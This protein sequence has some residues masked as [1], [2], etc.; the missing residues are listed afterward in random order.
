MFLRTLSLCAFVLAMASCQCS[1][2]KTLTASVQIATAKGPVRFDVELARTDKEREHGLMERESM[3]PN[4]GMLFLFESDDDHSFWMKN[5][6]LPLDLIFFNQDF[7]VVGVIE[8][9]EPM[10]RVSRSI[11]KPSRYVLEVNAGVVQKFGIAVG[12]TSEFVDKRK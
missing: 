9:M 2:Q 3:E 12:N 10:S 6:K 7:V 8:N 4:K 1:L 5:T 11:G